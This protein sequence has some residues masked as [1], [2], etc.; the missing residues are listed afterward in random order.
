MLARLTMSLAWWIPGML[1]LSGFGG[2]FLSRRV[3]QPVAQITASLRSIGIGSLSQRLPISHARDELQCLAETCNE[4]LAR[5]ENAV[6]RIN[7]FTADASHELRSPVALIRTVAE[8][9]LRNPRID[10]DSKDAFEEILAKSVDMRG[11]FWRT[12]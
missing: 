8:Y 7:R 3:L 11:I 9:A 1:V 10:A 6:E 5:L 2:Y 12:C 4:M